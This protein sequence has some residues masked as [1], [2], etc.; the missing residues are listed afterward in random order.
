MLGMYPG[1]PGPPGGDCAG[2]VVAAGRPVPGGPSHTIGQAVFGLASGCLGSHVLA[3]AHTLVPMP[4]CL[5]FEAASTMPTVFVTVDAALHQAARMQ[6]GERV[7]VHAAAG[8]VGLAAVQIINASGATALATAGGPAKRGLLRSLGVGHMASSRDLEFVDTFAPL[9]GADIVLNTL[10]SS[11]MVA[12]SL[13]A[14]GSG[15]RFVEISKRDIWSRAR[16]LQGTCC[17]LIK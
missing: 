6:R 1:D 10:T 14:L 3:S 13:A 5:S 7:L 12:A 11:G 16:M 2:V 8:G 4:W 9:G 17:F 15:G